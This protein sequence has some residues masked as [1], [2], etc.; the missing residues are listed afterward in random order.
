MQVI[1]CIYC[2]VLCIYEYIQKDSALSSSAR[3]RQRQD[4]DLSQGDCPLPSSSSHRLLIINGSMHQATT[5]YMSEVVGPV[6]G[7]TLVP[8]YDRLFVVSTPKMITT[9]T[10]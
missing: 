6:G 9:I 5:G 7:L 1:G 3:G 8:R 2:Y 10:S 4:V